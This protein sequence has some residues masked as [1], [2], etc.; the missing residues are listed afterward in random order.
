MSTKLSMLRQRMCVSE[1]VRYCPTVF[2][3]LLQKL[4]YAWETWLIWTR[5]LKG[6]N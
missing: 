6:H 3:E 1:E 5:S 2:R 4:C